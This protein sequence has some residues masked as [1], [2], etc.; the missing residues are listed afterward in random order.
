MILCFQKPPKPRRY[1]RTRAL[2]RTLGPAM[3]CKQGIIIFAALGI[4][5]CYSPDPKSITSDS[6]PSAIPAIKEAG[7]KNDR[8]AIPRLVKDLDDNDSAIRFA[9]ISALR[10]MTGQDFGYRYYDDEFTRRPAIDRWHQ[11]MKDHPSGQ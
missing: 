7:E 8:S 5:G 9:A 4:S 1:R 11:W 6:P 10:K 3:N 2:F